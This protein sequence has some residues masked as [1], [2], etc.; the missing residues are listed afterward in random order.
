LISQKKDYKRTIVSEIH[1][2]ELIAFGLR[3]RELKIR[4]WK[5]SSGV[6]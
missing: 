2:I 1:K 4:L 6:V 3:I 5:K